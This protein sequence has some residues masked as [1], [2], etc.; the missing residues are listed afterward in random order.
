MEKDWLSTPSYR[1]KLIKKFVVEQSQTDKDVKKPCK[2]VQL[3][4]LDPK[5]NERVFQKTLPILERFVEPTPPFKDIDP[6]R[7]LII[8]LFTIILLAQGQKSIPKGNLLWTETYLK[9]IRDTNGNIPE[10][11][12]QLL[13][14]INKLLS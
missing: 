14:L 2:R 13:P 6:D 4:N 9:C 7:I 1:P 3:E 12:K 10:N 8:T 5:A 11:I